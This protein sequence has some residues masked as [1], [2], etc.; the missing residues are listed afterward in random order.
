MRRILALI[1]TAM[2]LVSCLGNSVYSDQFTSLATFEFANNYEEMFGSDSLYVEQTYKV[3]FTWT[4]YLAFGHKVNEVSEEFE[5]GF[6]VSCL[7]IPESGNTELLENNNYRAS[8]T[9]A[10]P[11]KNTFVVFSETESMPE[12]HFWFNYTQGEIVGTCM[13][14][15]VRVNNSVGVINALKENFQDGYNMTLKA[16]G[17]REGKPTGVESKIRLAEFANPKDSIITT[18]TLFDLSALGVVDKIDFDIEIPEGC[19][20]PKVVCMDDFVVDLS[21]A[22]K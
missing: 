21:F 12:K 11:Q 7:S 14:K 9:Y 5:G 22:T 1:V 13:P 6:M 2:A 19:D 10:P 8:Q 20:V 15:S 17:Y 4:N 16:I 3:G 18:W